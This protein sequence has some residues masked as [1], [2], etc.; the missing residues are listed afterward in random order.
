MFGKL[1]EKWNVNWFQFVL[2][3]TTFALGGS[4]CAKAGNWLLSYFLAESDILY[5]I[6]YIP[7]ISLFWPMCVLLVSIPFGQFRFFVNYLKK[8]AVKLGLIKP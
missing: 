7:L 6:I 8:I 1:K 2:I 5:W 3:F 4:L